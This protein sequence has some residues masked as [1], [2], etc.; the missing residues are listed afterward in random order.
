MD[1]VLSSFQQTQSKFASLEAMLVRFERDR[2]PWWWG[3]ASARGVATPSLQS[4]VASFSANTTRITEPAR[5]AAASASTSDTSSDMKW[6]VID[7]LLSLCRDCREGTRVQQTTTASR[8]NL[9]EISINYLY[10]TCFIS[11]LLFALKRKIGFVFI[12][13]PA[14]EN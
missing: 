7:R 2:G 12:K 4:V 10:S 3:V 1:L 8:F 14:P 9:T 6:S 5:S 13:V 11:W